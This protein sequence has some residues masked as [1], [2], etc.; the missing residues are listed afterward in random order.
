MM[1]DKLSFYSKRGNSTRYL[2]TSTYTCVS[3]GNVTFV[4]HSLRTT[5]NLSNQILTVSM[6][7]A[8]I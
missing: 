3:A 1:T 8:R 7:Q 6:H 2:V 4:L 5:K